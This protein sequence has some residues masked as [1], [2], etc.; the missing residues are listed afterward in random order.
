MPAALLPQMKTILYNS[1]HTI[2]LLCLGLTIAAFA[3][4]LLRKEPQKQARK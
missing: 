4:N 3:I 1:L 2:M